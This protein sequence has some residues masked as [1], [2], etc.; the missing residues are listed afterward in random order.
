MT[1]KF[2]D[3]K[4]THR[5]R[6]YIP[7]QWPLPD[8]LDRLVT[9]SLG[10]FIYASTV[11]RYVA[12]MRHKPTDR[13]DIVLGIRLPQRDLPFAELDALYTHILA[14]V[15]DIEQVLDI[16]SVIFLGSWWPYLHDLY[17]PL[18]QW[19]SSQ[20]EAILSLQPGDVELYLGDMTSLV[21]VGHNQKVNIIHASLTDFLVDSTRSKQFWINPQAR[22]T[23]FA[24]RC[25]QSLQLKGKQFFFS[26]I[27]NFNP[28]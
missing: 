9:R 1:D 17:G 23:A 28:K 16:L 8:V 11:A 26:I 14:G 20:I 19:S 3:I 7:H 2:Q 27:H 5:L 22:H 10:Q 6:A 18:V 24:H 25:L 21:T 13:L 12:S 15:E 4:S